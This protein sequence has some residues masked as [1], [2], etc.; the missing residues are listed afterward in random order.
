MHFT[1]R[2]FGFGHSGRSVARRPCALTL[3]LSLSSLRLL[4]FDWRKYF[5]AR[6]TTASRHTAQPRIT[7]LYVCSTKQQR[8]VFMFILIV[9][10]LS[11]LQEVQSQPSFIPVFMFVLSFHV[12]QLVHVVSLP[13]ST[14]SCNSCMKGAMK[15]KLIVV[16]VHVHAA[17]RTTDREL[18]HSHTDAQRSV[19]SSG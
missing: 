8:V 16:S 2:R 7:Q 9:F 1:L 17:I 18:H 4:P 13:S 10:L 3:R 11:S 15:I 19:T 12:E 6:I 5:Q 14:L